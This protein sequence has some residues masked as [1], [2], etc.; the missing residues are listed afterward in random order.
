M[1]ILERRAGEKIIIKTPNGN[2]IQFVI[3]GKKPGKMDVFRVNIIAK[4]DVKII[5]EELLHPLLND[6]ITRS[7][8][9]I[10]FFHKQYFTTLQKLFKVI[11]N[12]WSFKSDITFEEFCHKLREME[13]LFNEINYFISIQIL[14]NN[15]RL[16]DQNFL[17]MQKQN[18]ERHNAV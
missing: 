8:V 11:S 17:F 14:D 7:V 3:N 12:H 18:Q 10:A 9:G 6:P 2:D 5:R 15:I 4:D 1:L 13:L 16:I